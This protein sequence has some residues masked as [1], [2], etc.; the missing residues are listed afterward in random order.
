MLQN[1]VTNGYSVMQVIWGYDWED[2]NSSSSNPAHSWNIQAAA[3]RPATVLNWARYNTS[4]SLVAFPHNNSQAGMCAEG[5][6]AGSAAIAYS[7]SWYGAD[8]YLDKVELLAGPVLSD[9]GQG[10]KV[11]N[12]A[13]VSVCGGT[14]PPA[15]CQG[16]PSGGLSGPLTYINGTENFVQGWTGDSSC[17]NTTGAPTTSASFN[18]WEAESILFGASGTQPNLSY[19][20]TSVVAWL[21]SS[22]STGVMNESGPQGWEFYQKVGASSTHPLNFLVNAV[23]NCEGPEGITTG[24]SA[25]IPGGVYGGSDPVTAITDDMSMPTAT[26]S[27][28]CTKSPG[29]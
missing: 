11:P 22:S 14:S 16:W 27:S 1:Y 4:G 23:A 20:N 25:T 6:S 28:V 29:H 2:T 13:P 17:A 8:Q 18:T 10:C 24:A 3:C 19:P 15:F 5:F 12:V 21:C 7:L 26:H 9:I